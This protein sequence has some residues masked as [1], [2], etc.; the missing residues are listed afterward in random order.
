MLIKCLRIH[1]E[2][3]SDTYQV[4]DRHGKFNKV[5]SKP[6]KILNL[7]PVK[8]FGYCPLDTDDVTLEFETPIDSRQIIINGS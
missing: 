5:F 7:P 2:P 6:I 1:H 8:Y 4:Y 3:E